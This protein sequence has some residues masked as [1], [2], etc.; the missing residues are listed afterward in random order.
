LIAEMAA[1]TREQAQGLEQINQ[2]V[3]EM[4]KGTQ[5]N[6]A[7]AEE[8]ASIMAT[9]K[10][11][12]NGHGRESGMAV[13]TKRRPALPSRL[14]AQRLSPAPGRE[15]PPNQVIPLDEGDFREF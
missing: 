11:G 15:I 8:L 6:A 3:A 1:A 2:A 12:Q 9:F 14:T 7:G 10:T 4:N 13:D 5:Q